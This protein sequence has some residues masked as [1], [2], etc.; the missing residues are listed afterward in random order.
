MHPFLSE[1]PLVSWSELKTESIVPDLMLALEKA[2]EAIEDL[3]DIPEPTY[4]NSFAQLA[5]I[6]DRIWNPWKKVL[7][8]S[9]VCD[10]TEIRKAKNTILPHITQF[11][12]DIYLNERL[13][14][15]LEKAS[16][17]E[18]PLSPIE[19]R[20][21]EKVRNDFLE[22]G[23]QLSA[24]DKEA[25]AELN[26]NLAQKT[27]KY[28]E[29]VLD[30]IKSWEALVHDPKDLEGLPPSARDAAKA[31]AKAKG[32]EDT[33]RFTLQR[34]SLSAVLQHSKNPSL[35]KK[36]WEAHKEEGRTEK[37]NNLPLVTE[38]LALR[39]QKATIL[40]FENFADMV[41]QS[42]MAQN[43][44]RAMDFIEDLHTKV[45]PHFDR[46][47][48]ELKDWITQ[49][50]PQKE[51]LNPWDFS[52]YSEAMRQA[53]YDFDDEILRPY[54]PIDTV[55][56]GLFEIAQ[57][58]YGIRIQERKT[59]YNRQAQQGEVEVWHESV[60]AYEVF[61]EDGTQIGYFYTDWFPRDSK[62]PGAWMNPIY[63]AQKQKDGTMS[64][65]VGVIAG[66]LSAPVEG[67]PALLKHREVV[68]VFHEFGH[69][70]HHLLGKVSIPALNGTSVAWDFVELPS[71][72]MENWCW[73]EAALNRFAKHYQSQEPIPQD[74]LQKMK[75]ARNFN[76]A[77]AMMRQLSFAKL[78]M[79]LHL[80]NQDRSADTLDTEI[81][82]FLEDYQVQYSMPTKSN[83]TCFGHLFS[84]PVGYAAGYYS[85]KWAEV[86]DADAFSRFEKEGIFNA[87]TGRDFCNTIL[88]KGN[89]QPPEDLFFDF[90][91]RDP[92]P[93]ALLRRD[94]LL[95]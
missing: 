83:V 7:H 22:N 58:L 66:N 16:L 35:R 57:D 74:L 53:R 90:M 80:R 48:Q 36:L 50:F 79:E 30:S 40:G 75:K 54:F 95:H 81:D 27:Q 11:S 19:M 5:R 85:Y 20:H 21:K 34:P 8:L 92:D 72:I 9:S 43:G 17:H 88:S 31:A 24:E 4:H 38:I 37:Y 70:L 76:S 1:N 32:Y 44:Q 73:Q 62:R 33:W 64:P 39:K 56:K 14:E 49:T 71:Q 42:R 13:W 47:V 89:S 63:S 93:D 10:N 6:F 86:L 26:R 55:L 59:C 29:N 94:G 65:N 12:S 68:T 15:T 61:E 77:Y 78:D 60:C 52:F 25:L 91:G 28:A 45:K 84:G 46:E 3:L 82:A 18:A 51:S 23:A 69:L 87:T 67:K 41:L 2:N